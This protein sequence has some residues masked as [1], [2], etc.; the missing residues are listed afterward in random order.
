MWKK[1]PYEYFKSYIK[2]NS[3]GIIKKISKDDFWIDKTVLNHDYKSGYVTMYLSGPVEQ[4]TTKSK[5]YYM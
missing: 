5:F 3:K 1:E 4:Y 2:I